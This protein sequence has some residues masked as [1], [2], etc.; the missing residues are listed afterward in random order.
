S[1][2]RLT[3]LVAMV[4][5]LAAVQILPFLDLLTH[6]ERDASYAGAG[7]WPMPLWGLANFVVPQFHASQS[8]LGT[9]HLHGQYW[10]KS[11]YLGVGVL[12]L[13]LAGVWRERR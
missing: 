11:Y 8:V 5:G 6:S 13:A 3:A 2:Q 7:V 4:A 12:I 10:T 9:Y 1:L